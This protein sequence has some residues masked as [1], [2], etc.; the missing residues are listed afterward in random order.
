MNFVYQ[1]TTYRQDKQFFTK[2]MEIVLSIFLCEQDRYPLCTTYMACKGHDLFA[3]IP[4][5]NYNP[6]LK[7]YRTGHTLVLYTSLI[8]AF[9]RRRAT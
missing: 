1:Y 3:C 2:S 7:T 8:I 4:V 9:F 6:Y 5:I